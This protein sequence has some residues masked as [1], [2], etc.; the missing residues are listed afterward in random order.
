MRSIVFWSLFPFTLPQAYKV[1]KN[2]PRFP[3][4]SGIPAGSIGE[5]TS[6]RF[7]AIGDSIIAGVGASTLQNA[8]VGQ[9]ALGLAEKLSCRIE[10]GAIG[11]I[12]ATTKK[13]EEALLPQLPNYEAD[14]IALSVGVNDVTSLLTLPKY[15][16][17]LHR[18]LTALEQH[19]PKAVIGV[20]GIPPLRGFPLLPT[21]LRSL[22][23]LRGDSFDEVIERVIKK[24]PRTVRVPL[25]FEPAPHKFSPDGYHP[26]E[27]SY[28][29]FGALFSSELVRHQRFLQKVS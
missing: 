27:E 8:L 21:P 26:S 22:I 15:E 11:K 28:Q 7:L 1:R 18:I 2:A 5:G 12:G 19:S 4:A 3:A 25:D 17:N 16:K 20:A 13:V 6:L 9:T 23:G 24:H 10:W 14:F 29:E